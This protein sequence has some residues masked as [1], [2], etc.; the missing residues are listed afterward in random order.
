[1]SRAGGVSIGP[2]ESLNLSFSVDDRYENVARNREIVCSALG[3]MP[4]NLVS[5]HQV[6]GRNVVLVDEKFITGHELNREVDGCDAIIT[7][8]KDVGL[9]VKVADCQGILLFDPVRNVA[10]AVHAGWRGL[11]AN[12]SGAAITAMAKNYGVNPANILAAVTPSLGPCCAFFS[13]PEKE[14]GPDFQRFIDDE[15]RVNLWDFS[16]EQLVKNGIPQ[17]NI[18]LA[19]VCT[20]CGAGQKFFSFR[21]D[22]G[23]GGRLGAVIYLR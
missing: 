6:H 16:I 22:R 15:K 14:L 4:E 5:M 17:E 10:A 20:M 2:Y 21:R 8:L 1:M 23:I 7:N 3:I 19:R 9:M 18:E 12:V 11:T 13:N